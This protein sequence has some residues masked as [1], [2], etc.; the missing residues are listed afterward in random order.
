MAVHGDNQNFKTTSA[1][2]RYALPANYPAK[3]N[4]GWIATCKKALAEAK[5]SP[6]GYE[7]R[8]GGVFFV[9]RLACAATVLASSS[10]RFP[11][12]YIMSLRLPLIKSET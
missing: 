2:K 10:M 8:G 12:S 3:K 1:M 6:R 5:A 7:A 11:L 9:L 4:S